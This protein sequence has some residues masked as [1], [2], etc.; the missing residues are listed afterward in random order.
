MTPT[1]KNLLLVALGAGAAMAAPA[2]AEKRGKKV[3]YDYVRKIFPFLKPSAP[4][5]P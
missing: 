1:L 4:L 5:I 2:D 3:S